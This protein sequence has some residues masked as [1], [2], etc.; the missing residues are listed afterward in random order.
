MKNNSR[1]IRFIFCCDRYRNSTQGKVVQ[2]I[3]PVIDVIFSEREKLPNI[4]DAL[5]VVI[6]PG[7]R[8]I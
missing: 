3:G 6:A 7:R 1:K 2:I 4:L 8:A 5:T